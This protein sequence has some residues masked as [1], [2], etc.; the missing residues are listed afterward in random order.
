MK[1]PEFVKFGKIP[2]YNRKVIITEKIDGTNASIYIPGPEDDPLPDG[3]RFLA[4]SRTR[5]LLPGED[6]N[7]GFRAWC[8]A[9]AEELVSV[10]GPGRHFGEWWGR[11]IQRGY[12]LD[13]RRF[14][15]FNTS[16]W[17]DPDQRPSCCHVVPVLR[18][19]DMSLVTIDSLKELM[20]GGSR[21]APGYDKPEGVVLYHIAAGEYMKWTIGDDGYKGA[22][23]EG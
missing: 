4:S 9:N 17:N 14:S 19:T 16:R 22:N 6:D 8:E 18:I 20:L 1:Y 2:R 11:G 21:A 5:W 7:Y 15:L 3:L 13:D 23:H 12:G 10:L